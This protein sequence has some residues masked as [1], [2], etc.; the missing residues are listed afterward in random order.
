MAY[1]IGLM[2]ETS[3]DDVDVALVEISRSYNQMFMNMLKEFL[4]DDCL[5]MSQ[6]EV[7]YSS[8]AKEAIVF[9]LLANE[10]ING[11]VSNVPSAIGAQE[12]IIL[13]NIRLPP[14]PVKIKE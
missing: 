8:V 3:L 2:S 4:K 6:E 5:V 13:G 12:S 9:A 7:G 1:S 10:T 14:I 11:N